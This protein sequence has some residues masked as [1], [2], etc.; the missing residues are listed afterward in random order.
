MQELQDLFQ[1]A[2]TGLIYIFDEQVLMLRWVS[3]IATKVF[4]GFSE[5]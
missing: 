1:K 5:L 4:H 2:V 3:G